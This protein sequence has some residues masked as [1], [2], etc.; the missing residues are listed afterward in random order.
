MQKKSK[1]EIFEELKKQVERGEP[2]SLDTIGG[3]RR[4]LFQDSATKN[5]YVQ[6]AVEENGK[7]LGKTPINDL[8]IVRAELHACAARIYALRTERR[9]KKGK[10]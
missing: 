9:H 3:L 1:Q 2:L 5:Y 4:T 10:A 8:S 6:L 7:V